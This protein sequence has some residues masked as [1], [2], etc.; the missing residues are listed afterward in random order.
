MAEDE[1]VRYHH[2]L[3]G[4]AC[5]QTLGDSKGQRISWCVQSMGSQSQTQPSNQTTTYIYVCI[6]SPPNFPPIKAA[7]WHRA[8]FPV[9]YSRSLLVTS[10]TTF[11]W[12]LRLSVNLGKRRPPL[13]HDT[14]VSGGAA[15]VSHR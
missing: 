3:S 4:H 7:T 12:V 14:Q 13:S 10:H 6:H 15:L 1:M 5:E 8:E 11:D 2:Q 9:V